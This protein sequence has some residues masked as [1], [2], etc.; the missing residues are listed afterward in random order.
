MYNVY[1]TRS[2]YAP[3]AHVIS[4]TKNVL[5]NKHVYTYLSKYILVSVSACANFRK[6]RAHF[7][8]NEYKSEHMTT[9]S[10]CHN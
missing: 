4:D 6:H 8:D 7:S 3:S 10:Y 2:L 5:H 1:F 9:S